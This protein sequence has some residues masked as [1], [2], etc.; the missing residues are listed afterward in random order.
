MFV[1]LV[2]S[3]A[4]QLHGQDEQPSI[5]MLLLQIYS[6]KMNNLEYQIQITLNTN[7]S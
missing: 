3:L 6:H 7:N 1:V 5:R 2:Q 4:I